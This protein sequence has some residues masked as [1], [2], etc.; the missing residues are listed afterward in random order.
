M[1]EVLDLRSEGLYENSP[2]G[3]VQMDVMWAKADGPLFKNSQYPSP[4]ESVYTHTLKEKS[5]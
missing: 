5:H 1:F 3:L 4:P 2:P